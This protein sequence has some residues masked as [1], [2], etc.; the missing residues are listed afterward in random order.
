[1]RSKRSDYRRSKFTYRTCTRAS[2]FGMARSPPRCASG[3]SADSANKAITWDWTQ[4]S[5][6]W[7]LPL[8]MARKASK[9]ADD[10]EPVDPL[11]TMARGLAEIVAEHNLSEL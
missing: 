11:V 6:M 1:M 10:D 8:A 7:K 3:R 9:G 4:P 2:R 5:R